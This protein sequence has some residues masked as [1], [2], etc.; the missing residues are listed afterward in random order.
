MNE[1]A[2]V[3]VKNPAIRESERN[4]DEDLDFSWQLLDYSITQVDFICSSNFSHNSFSPSVIGIV[5]AYENREKHF[6]C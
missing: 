5:T 1:V 4:D 2:K 3:H 6:L